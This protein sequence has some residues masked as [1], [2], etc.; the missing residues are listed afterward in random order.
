MGVFP[1]EPNPYLHMEIYDSKKTT[2]N[3]E[4]QV[5][6]VQLCSNPTPPVFNFREQNLSTSSVAKFILEASVM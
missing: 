6:R 5:R 1:R 4:R 3:T 2:E